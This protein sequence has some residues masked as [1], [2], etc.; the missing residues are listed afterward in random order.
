[1]EPVQSDDLPQYPFGPLLRSLRK[2]AGLSQEELAREVDFDK[3]YISRLELGSRPCP[4][5]TAEILASALGLFG[6]ERQQFLLTAQQDAVFREIDKRE[7][8]LLAVDEGAFTPRP[9]LITGK[10]ASGGQWPLIAESVI[11]DRT[12]H[13]VVEPGEAVAELEQ[14]LREGRKLE[15]LAPRLTEETV[16]DLLARYEGNEDAG[17]L[18][19]E[20]LTR[21][22]GARVR[23]Y[24]VLC[25]RAGAGQALN[26]VLP[27]E[28]VDARRGSVIE[29]PQVLVRDPFPRLRRWLAANPQGT[30]R[31]AER[32]TSWGWNLC[33]EGLRREGGNLVL[34]ARLAEYGLIMDSCD[35]LIDEAC[36]AALGGAGITGKMPLRDLLEAADKP[37]VSAHK[38]AAGIGIAA[39]I[40]CVCRQSDGRHV[41]DA[42]IGRRSLNVGTYADTWHVAPAGMFNWR[43]DANEP[44]GSPARPWGSYD[45]GDLLRSVLSEYAEETRNLGEL[46]DNRRRPYLEGLQVVRELCE[47]ARFEFTGIAVD[48][49]NLRPEVCVLIYV[50]DADWHGRQEFDL[51]YE[52]GEQGR[53]VGHES[54]DH[55]RQLTA[56]TVADEY[57]DLDDAALAKL[58]PAETV[59]AGAAAFWLGVDRARELYREDLARHRR[60]T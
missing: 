37:L 12:F 10:V 34:S 48:L 49:A 41:L 47:V 13:A 42:L 23:R 8:E 44:N 15:Y 43:F 14:E 35:S 31:E 38:R 50:P 4:L 52:Y 6:D 28:E 24:P 27:R 59:A 5:E 17:A 36:G 1:V 60:A 20:L 30:P 7:E 45:P 3:S 16:N 56:V 40:T 33:M 29:P 55:R 54:K 26:S 25:Y 11:A 2:R 46:E 19:A 51:N 21:G 9:A 32:A 22:Q 39:L 18:G 53:P 58:D 57:E